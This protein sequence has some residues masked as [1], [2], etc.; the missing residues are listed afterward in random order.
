MI[1][2]SDV[3]SATRVTK[4]RVKITKKRKGR[5]GNYLFHES[6]RTRVILCRDEIAQR[7]Y[8]RNMR[9]IYVYTRARSK[10]NES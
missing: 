6:V 10:V 8:A 7:M 2:R 4:E 9:C 3:N 5:M 1:A